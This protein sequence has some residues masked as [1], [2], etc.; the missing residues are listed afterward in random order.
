MNVVC[1]ERTRQ[2]ESVLT[3]S[4]LHQLDT[5]ICGYIQYQLFRVVTCFIV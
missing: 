4:V 1:M 2:I 5:D 3:C